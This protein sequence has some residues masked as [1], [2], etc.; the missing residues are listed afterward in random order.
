[1]KQLIIAGVAALVLIIASVLVVTITTVEGNQL[2]V[3]ETW[4]GGVEA[5]PLQPKTYVLVPGFTQKVF[6]YDMSSQVFVMND[7][8]DYTYGEGRSSDSY[9]VQSS[10]GQ[11]MRISLSVR[12]RRDPAHVVDQHKTVRD[13]VEEKILRPEIM[14]IVKDCAT[15]RTALDAY[16]GE[17]L[18]KLQS[19]ISAAL[20]SHNSEMYKR[21]ITVENFVIE[22]IGLDPAYVEQIK[23][24]QV[25]VQERLRAIEETRAA[26]ARAERAKAEAQA[27]YEKAVVDAKRDKEVGILSAER[28]AEQQV[29]AAQAQAKQVELAAEAEKNR[30][31]LNAQGEQTSSL[32]R[33]DAITAIG[34]AE[35][36][37]TRLKLGAYAA[38]G[39]DAFVRIEVAK[40]MSG[41]F[42]N[43][44]GYLPQD[45]KINLLSD[46]FLRAIDSVM[47]GAAAGPAT[48]P[49]RR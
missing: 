18:V 33:A 12:W 31:V 14:R 11:D 19:D 34:K 13:A 48:T 21:G 42:Q 32:L 20:M 7:K 47:S 16:S 17:G 4:G 5:T 27:A 22:H 8:P 35:A 44:S 41:A 26:E 9:L 6:K 29:L 3:K 43:I 49:A 25:A 45:M 15:T 38:E 23:A 30:M 1:M 2:G 10:E 46:S 36:E 39:A 24:R 28:E 37:A 40:S